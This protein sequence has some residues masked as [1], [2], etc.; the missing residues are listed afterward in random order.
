MQLPI[1]GARTYEREWCGVRT[2]HCRRGPY[3]TERR[4]P[5]GNARNEQF[6]GAFAHSAIG[7]ALMS[8]RRWRRSAALCAMLGYSRLNC[9]RDLR[10]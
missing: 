8:P 7:V 3:V 2:R 6:R 9:L 5:P 1:G 10:A 4:R